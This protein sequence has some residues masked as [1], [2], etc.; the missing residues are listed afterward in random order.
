MQLL[1]WTPAL[2]ALIVALISHPA[3]K[4]VFGVVMILGAHYFFLGLLL[5]KS[6]VHLGPDGVSWAEGPLPL[7]PSARFSLAE[8]ERFV[9]V[10][11]K[12]GSESFQV[13]LRTPGKKLHPLPMFFRREG[14]ERAAA[15]LDELLGE[16]RAL[17]PRSRS[18]PC[19][20][21]RSAAL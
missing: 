6:R 8:A 15:R 14:A 17:P 4:L 16:A 10:P 13:A 2:V 21:T 18:G 7:R 1:I 9:V 19:R 3:G 12:S 5:N 11:F 20:Q